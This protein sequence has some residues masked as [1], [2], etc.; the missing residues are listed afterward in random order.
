VTAGVRAPLPPS[1]RA[2]C[3]AAPRCAPRAEPA[4]PCIWATGRPAW[5]GAA[6]NPGP[7]RRTGDTAVT[8]PLGFPPPGHA[9]DSRYHRRSGSALPQSGPPCLAGMDRAAARQRVG[10]LLAG[11]VIHRGL[12][13]PEACP[14]PVPGRPEICPRRLY[15]DGKRR[16]AGVAESDATPG[17]GSHVARSQ[18]PGSVRK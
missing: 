17:S 10:L 9:L 8:R 3:T 5:R 18:R 14:G 7:V 12:S 13:R 4:A 11:H 6:D 16:R 2:P 1:T 15:L